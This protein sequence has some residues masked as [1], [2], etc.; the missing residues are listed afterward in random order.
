MLHLLHDAL[1]PTRTIALLPS[2]QD[3]VAKIISPQLILSPTKASA[4][5]IINSSIY[6]WLHLPV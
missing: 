4:L 5:A 3:A 6:K 1:S 2:S